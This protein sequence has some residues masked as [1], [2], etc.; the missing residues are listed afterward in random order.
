MP[1]PKKRLSKSAKAAQKIVNDSKLL[2]AKTDR[3]SQ[4]GSE[5]KASVV[6]PRTNKT[7][8][9]PRPDKKRG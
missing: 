8:N 9:K 5:F 3:E 7:A 6:T 1:K 2:G 4:S